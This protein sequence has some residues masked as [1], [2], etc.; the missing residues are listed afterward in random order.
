M[1]VIVPDGVC[2]EW[3]VETFTV[4]EK[5]AQR[6]KMY[7]AIR[8]DY[9]EY[10]P[11]GSYVR[12]LR[13]ECVIMSNTPYEI[14]TNSH[15]VR[16]ARGRVLINGLGLGMVLHAVLQKPEVEH[17]TVVENCAEVIALAWP[18]FSGNSRAELVQANAFA[19]KP[20]KGVYYDFVWHDVWDNVC[21]TNL[22]EMATLHRKYARKCGWQ[23]SWEK[24]RC[25]HQNGRAKAWR[26]AMGY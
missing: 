1:K 12:L 9:T 25:R 8:M 18:S 4:S 7:A 10:V 3:R 19:H 24:E 23:D 16:L 17:V 2:G 20:P 15:F 5:E 6:T 26:L 21:A 13:G 11:V 14:N 22:V